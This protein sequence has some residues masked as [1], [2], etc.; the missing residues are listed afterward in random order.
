MGPQGR[1]HFLVVQ[2]FFGD[3]VV[4]GLDAVLQGQVQ[5]GGGFTAAGGANQDQVGFVVVAGTGAVVVIPWEVY[6][7]GGPVVAAFVVGGVGPAPR[8]RRRRTQILVQRAQ[9]GA[10]DGWHKTFGVT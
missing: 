9:E 10:E 6:R 8:V 1:R 3:R 2:V 4:G 7:M 5:A